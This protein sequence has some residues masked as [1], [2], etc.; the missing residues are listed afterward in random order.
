MSSQ[1]FG[2]ITVS[3]VGDVFLMRMHG[4]GKNQSVFNPQFGKDFNNALDYIQKL[5][6]SSGNF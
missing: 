2:S 1:N 6:T 5:I 3:I 4:G